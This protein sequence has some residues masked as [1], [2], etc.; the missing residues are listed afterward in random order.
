MY[1]P[2][3]L[4]QKDGAMTDPKD[5]LLILAGTVSDLAYKSH[6][7]GDCHYGMNYVTK[8]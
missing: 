7:N 4:L 6:T 3:P 1:T 2:L 5:S 8:Q